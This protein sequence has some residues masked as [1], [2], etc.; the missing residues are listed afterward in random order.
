M[1]Q[2]VI[3][4]IRDLTVWG[5]GVGSHEGLTIF[6]EKALPG[7]TVLVRITEKKPSYAKAELVEILER[8]EARVSPI[9]KLF[10][11]CGGCQIMHLNYQHQIELKTKR[12]KDAFERI[13]KLQ[14]FTLYPCEPSPKP[15][16]YRNKMQMPVD[17]NLK[18][19]LY[20]KRSHQIVP[21]E[22][23][24]IQSTSTDQILKKIAL[25]EGIR[26]VLVR[27]NR[28]GEILIVLVTRKKP[29][30]TIKKLAE[31][32]SL[33]KGVKGVLHGLNA[34]DDN[35]L[36]SDAYTL[37]FGEEQIEENVLDI[38]VKISPASFFQVNIEQAEYL[39]KKAYELADLKKGD[40]VLDAY[41]GIGVFS[42]Y[43]AKQGIAVIGIEVVPPAVED[44]KINAK[45]N[46]VKVDFRLGRVEDLIS[47]IESLDVIF[48]NPPRKGCE[49]IVLQAAISKKPKKIIYTSCDPATLARDLL[50][51]ANHGYRKIEA[52]PFD[53]FPQTMHV[54]TVVKIEKGSAQ[55]GESV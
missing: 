45:M 47:S 32:I 16:H 31:E 24:Y 53:M 42:T 7:E 23:C 2:E 20:A 27:S 46:D 21:V 30:P 18:L 51:F 22:T 43:L 5:E 13:G 39:Y 44:A 10:G 40:R 1:A 4:Y 17:S 49:E 19:G 38:R 33:L 37:L 3:I 35:V 48:L 52:Y 9:C 36:F 8:S 29:T 6:V 11:K 25:V 28:A 12:V 15:L 34:R 41:S 50:F 26:H 55:K 54:E 14:K